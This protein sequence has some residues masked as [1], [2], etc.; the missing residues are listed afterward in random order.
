MYGDVVSDKADKQNFCTKHTQTRMGISTWTT[1][2]YYETQT[3]MK[4][5]LTFLKNLY[6]KRVWLSA[7]T[8]FFKIK[9][10]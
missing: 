9:F 2:T 5:E 6:E 3:F 8:S 10:D 4:R 7:I 1:R